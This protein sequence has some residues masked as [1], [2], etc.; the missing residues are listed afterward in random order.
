MGDC[1]SRHED[2]K[3][4]TKSEDPNMYSHMDR[5]GYYADIGPSFDHKNKK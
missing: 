2:A 1:V 3:I 4:E 5:D